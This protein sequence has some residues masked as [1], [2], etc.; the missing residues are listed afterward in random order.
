MM[1]VYIISILIGVFSGIL[2]GIIGIGGGILMIPALSFFLG[3]NQHMAQGTTLAAMIPPIGIMAAYVYYSKGWVNIPVALLIAAGFLLGGFFGAR[4]AV[5][6]PDD[7]LRKI[8]GAAL[9]L[10]GLKMIFWK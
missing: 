2:G 1:Q 6:F 7:I 9:L 10:I 4:F 3:F 5:D 8:F